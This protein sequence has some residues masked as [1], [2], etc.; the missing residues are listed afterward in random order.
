MS[1]FLFSRPGMTGLSLE[2]GISREVAEELKK[3]GHDV[4][5]PVRGYPRSLFGRGQVITQGAWWDQDSANQI[6][7]R[8]SDVYWAGTDPRADGV[9]LGY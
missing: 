2:E 9:A 7:S 5:F 1:T 8:S 6:V 3:R 4:T